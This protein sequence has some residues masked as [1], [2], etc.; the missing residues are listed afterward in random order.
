[1]RDKF[2]KSMGYKAA[3]SKAARIWNASHPSNPVGPYHKTRVNT[4]IN[5]KR[6]KRYWV[7]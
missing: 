4:P 2:A 5:K 1:M 7:T 6:K 3:Q